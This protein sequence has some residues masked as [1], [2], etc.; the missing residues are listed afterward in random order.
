MPYVFPGTHL[1]GVCVSRRQG[2]ERRKDIATAFPCACM[3]VRGWSTSLSMPTCSLTA[4]VQKLC[5]LP[6]VMSIWL[7]QLELCNSVPAGTSSY[8]FPFFL[9]SDS[10]SWRWR[11]DCILTLWAPLASISHS[12]Q[13]SLVSEVH[14]AS[15]YGSQSRFPV[16]E[17]CSYLFCIR[18]LSP[19]CENLPYP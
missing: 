3:Q 1:G 10:M 12:R 11:S 19:C 9:R 8:L 18:V 17:T 5:F 4:W 14:R 13:R 2:T 16:R 7:H 15:C 6:L